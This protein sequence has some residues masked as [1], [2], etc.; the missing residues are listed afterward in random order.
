MMLTRAGFSEGDGVPP[1]NG[2][3]PPSARA[4]KHSGQGGEAAPACSRCQFRPGAL[5][6]WR[7]TDPG[8]FDILAFDVLRD[9]VVVGRIT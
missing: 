5:L 1:N 8:Q 4:E 6:K 9:G 3:P 2:K 7:L